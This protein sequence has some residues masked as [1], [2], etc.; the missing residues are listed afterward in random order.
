MKESKLDKIKR[1][2]DRALGYQA[3]I[4][5]AESKLAE[6]KN[7]LRVLAGVNADNSPVVL[8]GTNGNAS[9]AYVSDKAKIAKGAAPIALKHGEDAPL[10]ASEWSH[11]FVE[12]V[13]LAPDFL[14]RLSHFPEKTRKAVL[15]I[16]DIEA[17]EPRVTLR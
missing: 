14:D 17:C 16:I 11:L 9:V 1:V 5:D 8:A 2:V 6:D 12:E 10:S 3:V 13:K 15:K 4:K 7:E